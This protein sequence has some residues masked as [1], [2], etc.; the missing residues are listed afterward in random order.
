M[1]RATHRRRMR[2]LGDVPWYADYFAQRAAEDSAGSPAPTTTPVVT[3]AVAAATTPTSAPASGCPDWAP[4]R[5]RNG[6]CSNVQ[7]LATPAAVRT[8][9]FTGAPT[10]TSV[11]VDQVRAQAGVFQ[12]L[13][14]Q[15][16]IAA[17]AERQGAARG[18][19]VKCDVSRSDSP[20]DAGAFVLQTLCSVNGQPDFAGN[21]L[22]QPGGWQIAVTELNR[23]A[24]QAGAK[25]PPVTMPGLLTTAQGYG[26]GVTPASTSS[27]GTPPSTTTSTSS[28]NQNSATEPTWRDR[29]AA[30][31]TEVWIGAGVLV[32]LGVAISMISSARSRR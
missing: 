6:G 23:A 24:Q 28:S 16:A 19:N 32:A 15:Q 20:V 7:E 8:D 22:I 30:V 31:P 27:T 5:S 14:Q 26:S 18:L 29:L 25:T 21:L 3:A 4:F 11:L 9:P 17:E 2:G 1:K 12:D 13:A 10:P